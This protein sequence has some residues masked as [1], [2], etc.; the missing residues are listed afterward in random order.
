[1]VS[2]LEASADWQLDEKEE[3]AFVGYPDPVEFRRWSI[4]AMNDEKL[5]L[6][7]WRLL[8]LGAICGVDKA[9]KQLLPRLEDRL[10]WLRSPVRGPACRGMSPFEIMSDPEDIYVMDFRKMLDEG[11]S[12]PWCGTGYIREDGAGRRRPPMPASTLLDRIRSR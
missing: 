1:M 6:D 7:E 11:L 4:A 12:L 2:F 9:M 3:L 8:R 10:I 5:V